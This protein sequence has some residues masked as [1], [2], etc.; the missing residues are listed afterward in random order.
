MLLGPRNPVAGFYSTWQDM[1]MFSC[2]ETGLRGKESLTFGSQADWR[3]LSAGLILP[4]SF[5][6]SLA[7]NP[8]FKG[9]LCFQNMRPKQRDVQRKQFTGH[10]DETA[11]RRKLRERGETFSVSVRSPESSGDGICEGPTEFFKSAFENKK[12]KGAEINSVWEAF[13]S[14]GEDTSQKVDRKDKWRRKRKK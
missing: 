9:T 8:L 6:G 2:E 3:L 4:P 5:T 14:N 11:N 12:I 13:G 1:E 10:K 7:D